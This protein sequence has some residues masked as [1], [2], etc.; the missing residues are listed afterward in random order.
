MRR[1]FVALVMAA[2]LCAAAAA[3]VVSSQEPL[4]S[5]PP[6][7][8]PPQGPSASPLTAAAIDQMVYEARALIDQGRYDEA[9]AL[10][11]RAL[12]AARAGAFRTQEGWALYALAA[13][14]ANQ[15]RFLPAREYGVQAL[16][17]FEATGDA[18]GVGRA[19]LLTSRA[20]EMAGDLTE[21][22]RL[23]RQAIAAF[24]ETGDRPNRAR[25]RERLWRAARMTGSQKTEQIAEAIAD[26]RSGNN[27]GLIAEMQHSLGDGYFVNGEYEKAL[28]S[29]Q[30]AA[31]LFQDAGPG[32]LV[33]LGT[34][35]NSIGRLYRVHGQMQAALDAQLKALEIHERAQS[36]FELTQSLN[37][38]ASVLLA[39]NQPDRARTYQD[40]ALASAERIAT[41]RIL[42][43]LNGNLANILLSQGEYARAA[44][45]LEGVVARGVDG[46]PHLRLGMLSGAYWRLGRFAEALAAADKMV[47]ACDSVPPPDCI[48]AYHRRTDVNLAL[49]NDA[50]ALADIR[51]AIAR[52]EELRT[53]LVPSDFF[54]ERY[55]ALSQDAYGLAITLQLRQQHTRD[56]LE[57]AELGRA[58]AFLDLLA[59]RDVAS[60]PEAAPAPSAVAPRDARGPQ[61][62]VAAFIRQLPSSVAARAATADDL[63]ALAARLSSTLLMYWVTPD[64][65]CIWVV[66]PDGRI[67]S[68]RVPVRSSRLEALVAA[69]V[70]VDEPSPSAAT[71]ARVTMR[72]SSQVSVAAVR[73]PAWRELYDLL[74][75]PVRGSLPAAGGALLTIIPHGPLTGL[76]FAALQ[77]ARGRYLLEDYTLH[78]APAGN[79]L[80]A[81]RDQRRPG[82]RTGPVLV[83]A[84]ATP[85]PLSPLER[86]LGRLPGARA[87]ARSIATLVPRA[88][89]TQLIGDEATER[90]VREA[91][92]GK[93]VIHVATHAIAR[94]SDP[95]ASYLAV[96]PAAEDRS[97]GFF[98]AREIYDLKLDADLVVLTACQSGGAVTGDGVATFARAFIHAGAPSLIVSQ[99]DVPDEPT[100]D[101]LAGFYRSWFAGQSKARALQS[102]QLQTLRALREGRVRIATPLGP[103]ALPEHPVFWAGFALIGEPE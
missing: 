71:P 88:R 91:A 25:A 61:T 13:V 87:E 65:V 9:A 64:E 60:P 14:A 46:Y 83:V 39:M 76:S 81:T 19:S 85:P 28:E 43:F 95:F 66:R 8:S 74:V 84:D 33:D 36:P 102:A 73:S 99:W 48:T 4:P 101:L 29:L 42:D 23:A 16:A 69:T 94:N 58:R 45:V 3:P 72:G 49:G 7:P 15:S 22:E 20:T 37:A 24:T 38:V 44:T 30:Q 75:R 10:A 62:D 89:L 68:E 1:D 57:T 55:S 92:A 97:D 103:V 11:D 79:V 80:Q 52:T 35:H 54:K 5:R 41:P 6:L 78:Y 2:G 12:A 98:T 50:A 100:A 96:G 59:S 40:R 18:G 56:A 31:Q 67:Q 32:R 86:A 17:I 26:A 21:A 63:A 34:V 53:K 27:P 93:A 51:S 70:P 77:D 90:R 47:A 82:A